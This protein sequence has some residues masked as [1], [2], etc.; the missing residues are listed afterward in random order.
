LFIPEK[1]QNEKLIR[2]IIQFVNKNLLNI[3]SLSIVNS[4][5]NDLKKEKIAIALSGGVDSICLAYILHNIKNE[6]NLDI[7]CLNVD[8][9]IKNEENPSFVK[10]FCENND[11]KYKLLSC[12]Y[13]D[14]KSGIKRKLREARYHLMVDWCLKNDTKYLFVGHHLND[15]IETF[16]MRLSRGS[17]FYGLAAMRSRSFIYIL[18]QN[19]NRSLSSNFKSSTFDDNKDRSDGE[20]NEKVCI[21]RPFLNISKNEIIK[22]AESN[23]ISWYEDISN[24]YDQ[25]ERVRVR[26]FL[27]LQ[28][29]QFIKKCSA[30]IFKLKLKR[31]KIDKEVKDF[32]LNCSNVFVFESVFDD[33][34]R[35]ELNNLTQHDLNKRFFQRKLIVLDLNKLVLMSDRSIV[36]VVNKISFLYSQEFLKNEGQNIKSIFEF[37]KFI[38]SSDFTQNKVFLFGK[39]M[40]LVDKSTNNDFSSSKNNIYIFDKFDSSSNLSQLNN[41]LDIS[42]KFKILKGRYYQN[43]MQF[44]NEFTNKNNKELGGEFDDSNFEVDYKILSDRIYDGFDLNKFTENIKKIVILRYNLVNAIYSSFSSKSAF[45]VFERI[46]LESLLCILKINSVTWIQSFNIKLL[47]NEKKIEVLRLEDCSEECF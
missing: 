37:V 6:M 15:D 18:N 13:S 44:I 30:V 9:N 42:I 26:K 27:K 17:N 2:N 7:T 28:N 19:P 33:N 14:I 38:K 46:F 16:L 1:N 22:F 31:S 45:K 47:S 43:I 8:Y 41:N 34:F 23:Q 29:D 12:D 25:F 5:K 40:W 3:N 36:R 10:S 32:L 39:A 21:L 24:D 35:L 11:I 4:M 20:T